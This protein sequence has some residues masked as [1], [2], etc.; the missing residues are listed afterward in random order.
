MTRLNSTTPGLT[1]KP[2]PLVTL[3]G[4]PLSG[5]IE[6]E[7]TN[8]SHFTADS[9]RVV[10]ASTALA[11]AANASYWSTGAYDQVGISIGFE[12]QAAFPLIL[13]QVDDIEY[14]LTGRTITL[15][16][17]DL[18]APLID[19]RTAEKFQNQTSGEI[20]DILADRHGLDSDVE[21]TDTKAGT[22]YNIDHTVLTQEQTEWDL[23]IYLAE[24]EGFD[25]WVSG[26]TLYF[27]PS[28]ITT[29]PPYLI[30]WSEPGDGTIQSNATFLK[31]G[32][33]ET[34]A[35]DIE[36]H[37]SSFNQKGQASILG[38]ARAFGAQSVRKGKAQLYTFRRPNL[39][40]DQAQQLAQSLLADITR[41]EM[42][43]DASLPGDNNLTTRT[44][45]QLVGTG[46]AWDQLYCP[47]TVTRRLSMAEGYRMEVRAKNHVT[48]STV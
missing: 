40:K 37:V 41:H 21:E 13:G 18:S 46:T 32:R 11:T 15:S 8:A 20:A 47:D 34:L 33:S 48:Q 19:T 29:N 1:R 28:P 38:V 35:K 31:L 14:D 17:R 43:L 26:N 5:V 6:V 24:Q 9:F 10:L 30:E 25:V 44:L 7:V 45:V 36:V 16:G 27:Q 22:Y 39:T 3:N 42:K 12:N 2:R 4:N 23:L